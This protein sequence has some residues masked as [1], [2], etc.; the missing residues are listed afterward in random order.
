M[1]DDGAT[2]TDGEEVRTGRQVAD[3]LLDSG[4]FDWH[5]VSQ[6][7]AAA[8]VEDGE[9]DF[10][11]VIPE[12]FSRSLSS[13]GTAEPQQAR[14]RLI[15]NDA[16]SYLSTTIANT[17]VDKVRDAVASEVSEEA[18]R[19]F[20]TGLADVRSG[21]LD[22]ADGAA[23][24]RDGLATARKGAKQL[25]T[26]AGQLTEGA[27][28]LDDGAGQLV[29]G[30]RTMEDE[31]EPLPASARKLA[32]G[33]QQVADADQR[34]ADIGDTVS[35]VV[36]D[37]DQ[38]YAD[39]RDDLESAMAEQGLTPAQQ[40]RLLQVYDRV[41][42]P[43]R[44]ADKAAGEV[45]G[46]LDTLAEGARD[47]ADGAGALADAVPAL[48]DGITDARA[49]AEQLDAGAAELAT[50][51]GEL[52]EG[53]GELHTGLT[54][55]HDG[56]KQLTKGL[57]EGA[58]QIP[59]L[60]DDTQQ[61][62]ADTIGNPVDVR[63]TA[64]TSAGSYGAGLAPFFLAL[65][66]WIGGYVLFLLVRPLSTRAL[67]ANQTPLRVALGGWYTPALIGVAQVTVMFAIV[68]LALGIEPANVMGTWLFLLLCSACFVAIIHA[69]NALLG[70]PGQ[71]LGL[72]LMVLQLVT[73][74]GTFPWQTIPG[75]LHVF[76]H[77]LPM[78]YAVDGLRQLMYGGLDARVFADVLVLGAWL[79]VALLVTSRV[80]RK[81]RVWNAQRVKPELVL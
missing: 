57:T 32:D 10:A 76:H 72:V 63:S 49:G 54:Q 34:I 59:A 41:G 44:D 11:L 22:G 17:V 58:E 37:I 8:G 30:L 9:F 24:L 28:Q 25:D 12:H 50:G 69:L 67:A 45:Q 81:K 40:R 70:T 78:S 53:A 64:Q 29:A 55:L 46:K 73:A 42:K 15:T 77:L 47:V 39:T 33:A 18:S 1:A 56:A 2:G 51:A 21:L 3:N 38:R 60:D 68:A 62:I 36:S 20:L 48:V 4:D 5:E 13:V 7:E 79:S 66:T 23:E 80:A 27:T 35:G 71:F 75:S 43:I 65:A 16:N 52:A 74:G 19:T 26:G 31:V 61:A 14:I 6:A